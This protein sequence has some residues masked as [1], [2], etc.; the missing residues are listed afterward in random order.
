VLAPVLSKVDVKHLQAVVQIAA[1]LALNA[2]PAIFIAVFA[3]VAPI[4]HQGQLAVSLTI[5]TYVAQLLSAFVVESRLATPEADHDISMPWW[6]ALLSLGS[7]ILLI[8][9]PTVPAPVITL[10]G[11]LGL[12]SGLLMA[13]TIGVVQGRWRLEAVAAVILV[14]GCLSA[15]LLA[16]HDNPNCV[17]V[18]A[19]GA[20][21]AVLC[22]FWPRPA[23]RESGMPPDLRRAAWVTGETASVG[24]VQPILTSFILV[25]LGPAASVGFRVVS[26]ISG[27][28]EPVLAYGRVRQLAHGHKGEVAHVALIFAAGVGAIV[29][30][31]YLGLWS[32][33]FGP[34]WSHS[35][36]P[37]LVIACLWKATM[38]FSTV[39]FAA[40]RRVGQTAKVFWLR[41]AGTALYVVLGLSF[42]YIFH[43]A[44]AVFLSFVITEVIMFL[45]YHFAARK[46]A[47]DY[48]S[49]FE[50][51]K[52]RND[53]ES[54]TV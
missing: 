8:V 47:P 13:R 5:G 26:T 6:M 9:S 49:I 22:R 40:L 10:L 43:T 28:L 44:T 50:R 41:A 53:S 31:A 32:L 17:R 48:H 37:A 23:H 3:R 34:A 4:D 27:V 38:L 52:S 24:I 19:A 21:L 12:S 25:V 35:L 30:A 1:G 39:P 51:K 16:V 42:L 36:V 11:V 54:E 20:M 45:P 46:A 7:G 15:L 2:F 14:A 18:L 29:V 33:I